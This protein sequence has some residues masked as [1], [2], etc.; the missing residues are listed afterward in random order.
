MKSH[1]RFSK[2]QRYGI[3][4]LVAVIVVFRAF[5]W[6]LDYKTDAPP[7]FSDERLDML[8]K[9]LDSIGGTAV[10]TK[11]AVI[12]P[13]NPNFI[14]DY[15]GYQIG[16][17]LEEIDKLKAYRDRGL[18]INNKEDFKKVT[19]VSQ[20]WL[21]SI[22]PYFKF[23]DWLSQSHSNLKTVKSGQRTKTSNKKIDL[24]T[25]TANDL[26]KVYGIGPTLSKRIITYRDNL[27]GGFAD[28]IELLEVYGLDDSLVERIKLDF[29]IKTPR[30]IELININ[31]A[32]SEELVTLPYIDYE[33]AHNIIEYRTLHEGISSIEELTKIE[34]FP[35]KKLKL[36]GLYLQF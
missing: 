11:T 19:G 36:I 27:N 1:F 23:P 26:Q 28:E 18:W 25:A 9:E 2:N 6:W 15:K 24:N 34:D 12:Y 10:E 4:L 21:D 7:N 31:T 22:A 33:I 13:F 5:I 29:Y 8:R 20:D 30:V 17:S 32:S 35:E 16:M 3:F 14:S